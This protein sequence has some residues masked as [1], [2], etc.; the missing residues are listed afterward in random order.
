[1]ELYLGGRAQGKLA[2]AL[3]RYPHAKVFDETC[4]EENLSDAD[5]VIWNHLHLFVK[6]WLSQEKEPTQIWEMVADLLDQHPG[7]VVICDEIGNGIVPMDQEERRYREETGRLL[8]KIAARAD[9]VE[10]ILCGISR[11]IK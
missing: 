7:M 2:L 4:R 5:V 6:T 8:C 9:K 11:R 1:M 10:R 3:Q